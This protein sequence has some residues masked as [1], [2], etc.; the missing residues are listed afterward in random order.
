MALTHADYERRQ[1]ESNWT[2]RFYSTLKLLRST[3]KTVVE[4]AMERLEKLFK[5]AQKNQYPIP[6]V[7]DP[8]VIEILKNLAFKNLSS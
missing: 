8:K 3:D 1:E 2:S 4:K 7:S 6:K 5:E